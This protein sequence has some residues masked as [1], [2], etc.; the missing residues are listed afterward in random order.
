[1]TGLGQKASDTLGNNDKTS[2]NPAQGESIA[3]Q[4][5]LLPRQLDL[6]MLIRSTGHERCRP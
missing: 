1:M 4:V 6:R 2:S 3:A 5:S